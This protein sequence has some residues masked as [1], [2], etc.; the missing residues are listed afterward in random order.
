MAVRTAEIPT[1]I[2]PDLDGNADEKMTG[3][4]QERCTKKEIA[5]LEAVLIWPLGW[6]GFAKAL[7]TADNK[8]GPTFR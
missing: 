2:Y 4:Y 7:K 6:E 5:H 1:G 8:K 3:H